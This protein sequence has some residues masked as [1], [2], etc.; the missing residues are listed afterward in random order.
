MTRESGYYWVKYMGDW[1]IAEFSNFQTGFGGPYGWFRTSYSDF[2]KDSDFDEID[3]RR[4]VR[5]DTPAA[6]KLGYTPDQL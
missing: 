5:D 3:E 1:E 2:I 4:I 6:H